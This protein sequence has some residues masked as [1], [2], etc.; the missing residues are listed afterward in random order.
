MIYQEHVDGLPEKYDSER[1]YQFIDLFGTHF[2]RR[3]RLGGAKYVSLETTS[4]EQI[5]TKSLKADISVR[6]TQRYQ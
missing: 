2:I 1:Y 4:Q 5:D 3:I 6:R